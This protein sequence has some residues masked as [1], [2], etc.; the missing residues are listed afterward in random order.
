MINYNIEIPNHKAYL[1]SDLFGF[2]N[3]HFGIFTSI[4]TKINQHPN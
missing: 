3:L 2:W 4:F 1:V